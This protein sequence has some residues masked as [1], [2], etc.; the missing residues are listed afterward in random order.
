[1]KGCDAQGVPQDG[2]DFFA[3]EKCCAELERL[4]EQMHAQRMARHE[5]N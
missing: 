1:M 4:M 5:Q 2:F 3:C